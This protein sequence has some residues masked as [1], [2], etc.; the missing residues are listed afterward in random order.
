MSQDN[1]H[2]ESSN[3]ESSKKREKKP[4]Q[5]PRSR[6]EIASY[7]IGLVVLILGLL[8]AAFF[9]VG[10]RGAGLWTTCAAIVF[11][12]IGACCWY[13]DM[14]DEVISIQPIGHVF[15]I[16]PQVVGE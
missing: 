1:R 8:S 15:D 16:P 6:M 10:H 3:S 12:V 13:Q 7:V 14:L 4:D 11:A 5:Q 2:R 9:S